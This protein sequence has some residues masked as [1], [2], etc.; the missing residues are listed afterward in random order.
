MLRKK[1][2][3]SLCDI[4]NGGGTNKEDYDGDGLTV[5]IGIDTSFDKW[6]LNNFLVCL[7][8]R[9]LFLLVM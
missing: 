9:V 8:R 6:I 3:S 7:K 2:N 5:S 1:G 4:F